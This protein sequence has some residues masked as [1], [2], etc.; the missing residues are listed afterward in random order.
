MTEQQL[1]KKQRKQQHRQERLARKVSEQADQRRRRLIGGLLFLVL[2]IGFIAL[3]IYAA[4]NRAPILKPDVVVVGDHVQGVDDGLLL[5]E[6]SDFQCPACAVYQPIVKQ[7]MEEY[8][9]QVTFVYR[10]FPLR[11]NHPNAQLAAQAAE[12]AGWQDK[13]W[14]MHDKLFAQQDQW[15]DLK[16]PT[17]QFIAYAGELD[18]AVEQFT[19]DLTSQEVI[20]KVD[21]NYTSG[22]SAGV[23]ST[24][25]FFINGTKIKAPTT[26]DG[27]RQ[28][29]DLELSIAN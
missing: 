6:Y 2:A 24:P 22:L 4:S 12:A 19:S 17:E 11:S 15:S 20:N 27:W 29:L 13:F 14:E 10:H 28:V 5:V 26:L 9:Q 7:V 18:L 21:D 8:S 1:T 16:D 3:M 23:D 25:S